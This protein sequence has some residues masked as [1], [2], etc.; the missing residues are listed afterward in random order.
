MKTI[1]PVWIVVV[2]ALIVAVVAAVVLTRP[3]I[4]Y[5]LI[6][7]Q[8]VAEINDPSSQINPTQVPSP[9]GKKYAFIDIRSALEYNLK[10]YENAINIPAEQMFHE[11]Y[12]N[13]IKELAAQNDAVVLYASRPQQSAGAW[14]LLKQAGVNNVKH[15]TGTF[16][17][18]TGLAPAGET[19]VF[20]EVP[21]IDTAVLTSMQQS[22]G[23]AG[24]AAT[25]VTKKQIVPKRMQ[26]STGGGC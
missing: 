11:E 21:A 4:P 15:F 14:L 3:E 17:Q 10:H 8:V 9:E 1:K 23:S 13:N 12:L 16:E 18:L 25:Q 7:E 26:P 22:A 24:S 20:L 6:V 5:E 19:L 2:G